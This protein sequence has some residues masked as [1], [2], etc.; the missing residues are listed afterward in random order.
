MANAPYP[1]QVK[2]E[3]WHPADPAQNNSED[4]TY[5]KTIQNIELGKY[6]VGAYGAGWGSVDLPNS[7][8]G[9]CW[10]LRVNTD[11]SNQMRIYAYNDQTSAWE[12]RSFT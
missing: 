1:D 10:V 5:L 9:G 4:N 8:E 12:S 7:P 2:V 11:A 6:K 3:N